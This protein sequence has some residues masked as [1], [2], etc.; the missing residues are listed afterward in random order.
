MNLRT[1]AQLSVIAGLTTAALTGHYA[2]S[3]ALGTTVAALM[4]CTPATGV[5]ILAP[6]PE[7]KKR[8]PLSLSTK[9]KLAIGTGLAVAIGVGFC[10]ANPAVGFSIAA[11]MLCT[12]ATAVALGARDMEQKMIKAQQP[13]LLKRIAFKLARTGPKGFTY[14]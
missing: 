3:P 7:K 10:A 4:L 6:N 2:A 9:A 5:A 12:P 1:K 14:G 8:E 13:S 11:L